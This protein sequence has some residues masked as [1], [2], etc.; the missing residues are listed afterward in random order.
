VIV[1]PAQIVVT[2]GTAQGVD[3]LLRLLRSRGAD[4]IAVEDPSLR[5]QQQ[6]VQ[7][8]GLALVAQPLDDEGLI[9][10]GLA[11]D[12]VLVTRLT[13]SQRVG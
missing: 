2:Q 11:A 1:D 10:D 7:A 13:S 12:A 9:V 4:R 3:V 5:R 8:A 6:R